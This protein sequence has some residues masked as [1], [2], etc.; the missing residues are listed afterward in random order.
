[1]SLQIIKNDAKQLTKG[2]E[3]VFNRVKSIYKNVERDVYFYVQPNV[4]R[5]IPNFIFGQSNLHLRNEME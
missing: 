4:G 3:K 5:L 2:E 1:M